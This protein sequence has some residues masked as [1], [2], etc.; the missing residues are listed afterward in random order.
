MLRRLLLLL[1]LGSLG[2]F[3]KVWDEG[4]WFLCR[5]GEVKWVVKTDF[6]KYCSWLRM[7]TCLGIGLLT[8]GVRTLQV[9]RGVSYDF[10]V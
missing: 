5:C 6:G 8:S 3:G 2:C 1:L 9:V 4:V 10:I 7:T